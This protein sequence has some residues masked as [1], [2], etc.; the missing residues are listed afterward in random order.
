VATF[1]QLGQEGFPDRTRDSADKDPLIYRH[2]DKC[3]RPSECNPPK[4][5]YLLLAQDSRI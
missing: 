1:P 5:V 2:P 3:S 4:H